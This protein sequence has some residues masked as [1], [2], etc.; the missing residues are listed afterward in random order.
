MAM[1]I[2]MDGMIPHQPRKNVNV[3]LIARDIPIQV[4]CWVIQ[5]K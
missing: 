3:K 1:K 2:P 4:S 5:F